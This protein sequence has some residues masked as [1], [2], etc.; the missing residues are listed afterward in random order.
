MIHLR[1]DLTSDENVEVEDEVEFELD[2]CGRWVRYHS[3]RPGITGV[4][5]RNL[6]APNLDG[7]IAQWRIGQE[8]EWNK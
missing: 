1:L 6:E 3:S 2:A 7:G 4:A 5:F 8:R